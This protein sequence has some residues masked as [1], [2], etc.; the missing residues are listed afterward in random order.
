[1][2]KGELIDRIAQM[3]NLSKRQTREVLDATFDTIKKNT[4]KKGGVQLAGF[5]TFSV[6]KRKARMGRNPQTGESIKINA[7]KNVKFKAG[8]AYKSSL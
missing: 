4:K 8:K 2:N 6:S 3:T 5:G 1:M 7:S